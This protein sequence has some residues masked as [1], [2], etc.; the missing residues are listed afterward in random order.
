MHFPCVISDYAVHFK[1]PMDKSK[2]T[3]PPP[4]P[5]LFKQCP[6]S[7]K[8]SKSFTIYVDALRGSD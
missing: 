6:C 5:P 7:R 8:E 1:P 3:P 2:Q 4:P